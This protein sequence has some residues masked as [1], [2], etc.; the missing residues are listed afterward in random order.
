MST[1]NEFGGLASILLISIL[2]IFDCIDEK[3]IVT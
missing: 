3:G 1:H 2:F